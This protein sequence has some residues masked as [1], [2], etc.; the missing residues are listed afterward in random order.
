MAGMNP[1]DHRVVTNAAGV[2]PIPHIP[3]ARQWD[4]EK[5]G[6]HIDNLKPGDRVVIYARIFDSNCDMC[7]SGNEMICRSGGIVGL[8][9]NG[10]FAEFFQY[11][12][13]MYSKYL[14]N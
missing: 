8:V 3:G 11:L 4:I 14:M 6:D 12:K 7:L 1:I 13:E 5:V 10:G 9:T 2:K